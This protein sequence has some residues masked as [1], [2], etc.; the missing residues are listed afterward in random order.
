MGER[1]V[2]RKLHLRMFGL[3]EKNEV[4]LVRPRIFFHGPTEK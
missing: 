3:K 2:R 1:K 4:I